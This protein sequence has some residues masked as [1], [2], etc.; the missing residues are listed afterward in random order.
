MIRGV[1]QNIT[2][3]YF[4][5]ATSSIANTCRP[6][7]LNKFFFQS[8]CVCQVH[9]HDTQQQPHFLS[10]VQTSIFQNKSFPRSGV[11][12]EL[13]VTCSVKS[14]FSPKVIHNC[15][16]FSLFTIK[17]NKIKFQVNIN[18][19]VNNKVNIK[20]KSINLY[21]FISGKFVYNQ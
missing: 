20:S 8:V 19:K 14:H 16:H 10:A 11:V 2:I 4:Y 21:P 12:V 5:V 18:N 1:V 17:L 15:Y 13:M 3:H 6:L 9:G 7:L